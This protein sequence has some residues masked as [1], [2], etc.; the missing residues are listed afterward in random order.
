MTRKRFVIRFGKR[1]DGAVLVE[2]AI[3]L[4]ILAVLFLGLAEFT[5][6]FSINRKLAGAAGAVADLVAQE[7]VV[8]DA[9]LGDTDSL[10]E[11]LIKPHSATPF[12]L[13]VVSVVADASNNTT[14]DWSYPAGSYAAGAAYTLPDGALT[15]PNSSIIIAETTYSFT[16]T[17]GHFLGTF[18]MNEAAFFRPRRAN[19][20]VKIN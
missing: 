14:V 11:E 12:Q 6:A 20:V 9:F 1:E 2:F 19:R 8:N 15:S 17:V 18:E 13:V 5:E 16:P 4:P 10:A 7:P 3:I